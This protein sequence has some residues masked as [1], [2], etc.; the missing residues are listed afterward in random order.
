M[1]NPYTIICSDLRINGWMKNMSKSNRNN[2]NFTN[3]HNNSNAQSNKMVPSVGMIGSWMD[4]IGTVLA[5]IGSTPSKVLTEEMLE[6]LIFIGNSLQGVGSALVVDSPETLINDR[7]G[8]SIQSIGNL[9]VLVGLMSDNE[10]SLVR[11]SKQGNLIQ[12]LGAGVST[13]YDGRMTTVN[14]LGN[15]LQVIGNSLQALALKEILIN[16]EE[17]TQLDMAGSWIQA[18]GTVISAVTYEGAEKMI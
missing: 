11:L 9:T 5:A 17:G 8:S 14:N 12:A 3:R 13:N 15:A 6:D 16:T 4:A 10:K 7:V 2:T 18:I 1:M